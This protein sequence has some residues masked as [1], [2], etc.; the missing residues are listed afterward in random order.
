MLW[1][2]LFVLIFWHKPIKASDFSKFVYEWNTINKVYKNNFTNPGFATFWGGIR[3]GVYWDKNKGQIIKIRPKGFTQDVPIYLNN[4][5]QKR[6]LIIFYPGVF[7]KPDSFISPRVIDEMEKTDSHVVVLPNII[8]STYLIARPKLELEPFAQEVMNQEKLLGEVLKMFD[9]QLIKN[10]HIYAE[11]LGSFQALQVLQNEKLKNRVN[12]LT[13]LWPPLNLK[14]AVIRFDGEI[15]KSF[16][17]MS[18]CSYWW[19]WP[20]VLIETMIKVTP[21]NLTSDEK[22]CLAAWVMAE[23]FVDSI[24]ENAKDVLKAK[25]IQKKL[26][27][28]FSDFI[29]KITPEMEVLLKGQDQRL[30]VEKLLEGLE[31]FIK[32]R[33]ISSEDDFLNH[34]DEWDSLKKKYPHL[35]SNVYLFPWGGHSGPLGVKE[36]LPSLLNN[37]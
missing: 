22:N 19:K 13:L 4:K 7:G 35:V 15:A 23:G 30:R 10:I 5:K 24:Q 37:Q 2:L 29:Q 32:V 6:D 21:I 17:I 1:S 18:S 34:L 20:R 11:S 26:P 33:L 3:R 16:Q 8:A 12:S 14:E 25:N 9:N 27:M 36:I 28:N 31:K